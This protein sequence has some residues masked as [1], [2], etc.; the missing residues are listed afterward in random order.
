MKKK[1]FVRHAARMARIFKIDPLVILD[2]TYREFAVRSA[3]MSIVLD[4]MAE[5]NRKIEEKS[6]AKGRR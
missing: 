3:A 2:S 6:K 1:A 4:D 5:E